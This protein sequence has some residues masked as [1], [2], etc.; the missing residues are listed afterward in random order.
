MKYPEFLAKATVGVDGGWT[1]P[2]CP[3]KRRLRQFTHRGN[4]FG[5]YHTR[6]WKK[7]D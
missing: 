4:H 3:K 6:K 2:I 1:C 5:Q 7:E